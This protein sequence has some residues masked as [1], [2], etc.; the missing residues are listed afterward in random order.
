MR[1][2]IT[3]G[4][5]E[6]NTIRLTERNVS[7]KHARLSRVDGRFVLEDLGSYNGIKV[8]GSRMGT[9]A[10]LGAGDQI[11][12]GD[13]RIALESEQTE[14]ASGELDISLSG[15]H[16]L[17]PPARLVMLSQPAPGAEFALSKDEICIGREE[18]MDVWVNHR[19]ISREH[20]KITRKVQRADAD[21]GQHEVSTFEIHD[22]DSANGVRVNGQEVFEAVLKQGDIV[23]LGQVRFR[24]VELGEVF[25]FESG[26]SAA[27]VAGAAAPG[28]EE[29]EEREGLPIIAAVLIL[30]AAIGLAAAIAT[31]GS[32]GADPS[33]AP[34]PAP[35]TP[36]NVQPDTRADADAG[37]ARRTPTE[38]DQEA[39]RAAL[40]R[41]HDGL[42]AGDL[43]AALAGAEAAIALVP[44]L[45][46]AEECKLYAAQL[47]ADM[48]IFARGK[49]QLEANDI[50]SA[51]FTMEQLSA[52][53]ELRASAE[54]AAAKLA[55]ARHHVG[56]AREALADNPEEAA[57]QAQMVVQTPDVPR[58]VIAD[59]QRILTVAQRRMAAAERADAAPTAP[60]QA[61]EGGTARRE[62]TPTPTP[63]PPEEERSPMDQAR[64][65]MRA[66]DN[67]CVVSALE[68]GR[69]RSAASLS[70]L[71]ETYRQMGNQEA[72]RRH[73]RTFV[74][75]YPDDRR[76]ANY[77]AALGN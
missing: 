37:P 70:L 47:I 23:E 45:E 46:G 28:E 13:Y 16:D 7:R 41:C 77:S 48:E 49:A 73:M 40:L 1:D 9:E 42:D 43:E 24:Y 4:R 64:E 31:S 51:Y 76:A 74:T 54:F 72:A 52:E 53:S 18:V 39:A 8:N 10:D 27:F 71:I 35:S 14:V 75:R 15:A 36:V 57:N 63:T 22:L 44:G 60:A 12:I 58:A 33:P 68:G 55:F 61:P 6:G 21:T 66:G 29:E 17:V 62:P 2:E 25:S 30:G 69:A 32:G 65:C 50:D 59:A 19:S 11:V 56:L 3:I 26:E 5:E 38:A 67:A 20:A 34:G